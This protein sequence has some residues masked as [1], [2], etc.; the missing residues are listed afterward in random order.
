VYGDDVRIRQILTN[1]LSN[2]IKYT[3]EG[4]VN[5][6][7]KQVVYNGRDYTAFIV[8]DTGVGIKKENFS[9]LFDWYEQV[10]S[11]RNRVI[12]GT[13]LGLP[14]TKRFIDM[15]D[16][17]ID[18]KSEFGKGS[19]FTVLLPLEKG[20]PDKI[21]KNTVTGSVTAIDGVNVLVVDDNALNL[22]V[23]LAYLE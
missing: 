4:F 17:L 12:S 5:F 7:V 8:K 16:G 2:A 14:I 21:E 23:A 1:I 11:P 10:D 9:K 19:V 6:Q 18:I 15:M 22:K 20:D 13:G 3:Q